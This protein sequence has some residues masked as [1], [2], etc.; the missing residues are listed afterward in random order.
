MALTTPHYTRNFL[1]FVS[2]KAPRY[3]V[4]HVPN[5]AL[6]TGKAPYCDVLSQTTSTL[7]ENRDPNPGTS[8]GN[9]HCYP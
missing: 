7:R 9:L 8:G 1:F 4:S 5:M 6:R 2:K 3:T